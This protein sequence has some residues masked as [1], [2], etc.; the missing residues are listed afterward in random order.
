MAI[1]N[2]TKTIT[3]KAEAAM[4]STDYRF[5]KLGTND[6]ECNMCGAGEQMIGIRRNSPAINQPVEVV[7]RAGDLTK[8]TIGSG[9]VTKGAYIKSGSAGEGIA[10]TTDED[11][12]GAIAM[13]AGADT[14]VITVMI[15]S[16]VPFS[17]PA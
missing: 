14:E 6:Q 13:E 5:V 15:V 17:N 10:T 16:P 4:S 1:E 9:G 3:L 11:K 2:I 12:V 7:T 8:L